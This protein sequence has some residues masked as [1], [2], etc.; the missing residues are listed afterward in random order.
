MIHAKRMRSG[1]SEFSTLRSNMGDPRAEGEECKMFKGD[2]RKY[3]LSLVN[4]LKLVMYQNIR[5]LM[6]FGK[7]LD[8]KVCY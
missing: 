5:Q 1:A 6:S 7:L 8:R 4:S 2:A 3:C